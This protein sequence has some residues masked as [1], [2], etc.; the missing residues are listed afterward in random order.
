[1]ELDFD[2][3]IDAILRN[4]RHDGPVLI[5][6][7]SRHLDADEIS[8][9]AENAMPEKSRSLYAAHMADCD[10]CRKILSSVLVLNS[11]AA[12]AAATSLSAITIAERSL[13]WYRSLFMF[14]NLA[15]V[16][17]GLV[18]IFGG[19]LAFSVIQNSREP[20]TAGVA[21]QP[22]MS[23][24]SEGGPRFEPGELES[25]S[26]NSANSAANA[27]ANVAVANAAPM[28]SNTN[29]AAN[30]ASSRGGPRA[31]DNNFALDGVSTAD[32]VTAP[33]AAAAPP[34]TDAATTGGQPASPAKSLPSRDD[35]L[36]LKSKL[37]DKDKESVSVLPENSRSQA[38]L[39]QQAGNNVQSGPMSRNDRQY[40]NQVEKMDARGRRAQKPAAVAESVTVVGKKV[41]SGRT[42]EL[43]DRVWYDTG[44]QG[45]PTINVRRGTAEFNRLDAGL[46]SIANSLSGTIVV[47]WGSKAY[48]IQ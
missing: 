26:S 20:L 11:E 35:D 48:R 37:E 33:A 3:E 21:D 13:P 16:M 44:Y 10:R 24:P 9:F 42:F 28:M 17:G 34:P 12:P 45:H 15:Y 14:P 2:K 4:A 25:F 19:F 29:A 1:M 27:A 43:K 46:R 22:A 32:T 47:V 39:K 6:D 30:T 5:G 7:A 36:A 31:G 8:A 18:L 23:A 40:N 41:V 38:M